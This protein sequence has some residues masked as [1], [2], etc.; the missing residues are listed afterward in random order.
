MLHFAGTISSS[1]AAGEF[2]SYNQIWLKI[3]WKVIPTIWLHL[4]MSPVVVP[5]H[6]AGL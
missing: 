1:V 4:F 3:L 6:V 2:A 5:T